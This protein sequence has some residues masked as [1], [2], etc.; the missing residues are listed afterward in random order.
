MRLSS[1]NHMMR[2]WLF[3]YIDE[4]VTDQY[5]VSNTVSAHPLHSNRL[6]L[7]IKTFDSQF[8]YLQV[9]EIRIAVLMKKLSFSMEH[10][11]HNFSM[12]GLLGPIRRFL[13]FF[14]RMKNLSFYPVKQPVL[15]WYKL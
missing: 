1:D 7:I 2:S 11:Q 8:H 15:L 9:L 10:I 13:Y 14:A 3:Y 6:K 12:N 4:T 5:I